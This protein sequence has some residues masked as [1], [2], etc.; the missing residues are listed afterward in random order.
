MVR[1][2]DVVLVVQG[3][4][5]SLVR[6]SIQG[7]ATRNLTQC[8]HTISPQRINLPDVPLRDFTVAHSACNRAHAHF[9]V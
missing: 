8:M 6:Q 7:V 5:E 2:D 4:D 9:L 1:L 3:F